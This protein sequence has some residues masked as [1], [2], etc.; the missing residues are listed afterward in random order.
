MIEWLKSL[1]VRPTE[2]PQTY[3]SAAEVQPD[4]SDEYEYFT[5]FAFDQE[6]VIRVKKVRP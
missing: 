1:V 3:R 2:A 5:E 4:D 6:Q